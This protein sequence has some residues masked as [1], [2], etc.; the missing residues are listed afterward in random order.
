MGETLQKWLPKVEFG[1]EIR[2]FTVFSTMFLM[3]RQSGTLGP[4]GTTFGALSTPVH[5]IPGQ[6]LT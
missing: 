1:V 5:S 2:F 4:P 3:L 6:L